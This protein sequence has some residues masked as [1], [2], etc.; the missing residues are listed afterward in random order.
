MTKLFIAAAVLVPVLAGCKKTGEN[1]YEVDRP[2]VGV[3][4]DTIRTPD[5]DVRME[6]RQVE[7]PDVDV[8]RDTTTIKVPDIDVN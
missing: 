5:V 7:V 2:V 4:K 6:D 8:K 3:E 1:E